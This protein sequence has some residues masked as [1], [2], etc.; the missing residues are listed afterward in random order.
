MVVGSGGGTAA[1]LTT[2][3][4]GMP[5]DA[6]DALAIDPATG[7]IYFTDLGSIFFKTKYQ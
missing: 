4:D 1:P 6:P 3:S 5:F 7:E 2:G